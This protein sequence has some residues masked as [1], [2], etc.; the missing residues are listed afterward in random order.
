MELVIDASVVAKWFLEEE[1]R[2]TAE[3]LRKKHLEKK[4]KLV[5]PTLLFFELANLLITKKTVSP[6][7]AGE[8][9]IVF[10]KMQIPLFPLEEEELYFWMNESRQ[11][12]ISAYDVA[13]IALAK[14][15]NCQF[16]TADKKLYQ[17]AKSLKFVELLDS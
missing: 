12:N 13:Y 4:I 3:N 14:S 5:A 2:Q 7:K 17:K 10:L 11:R 8:A 16:I 1:K 6:R 15:R 9:L